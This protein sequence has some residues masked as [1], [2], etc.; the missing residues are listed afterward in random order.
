MATL[1]YALPPGTIQLTLTVAAPPHSV[2]AARGR[3][4]T[5]LRGCANGHS[6]AHMAATTI[7]S[8]YALDVET[9]TAAKA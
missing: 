9:V 7:R 2:P 4:P 5:F 6:I 3:A 1:R 8:A